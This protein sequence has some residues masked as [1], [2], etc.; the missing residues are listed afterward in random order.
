M[1]RLCAEERV[2]RRSV[3]SLATLEQN[4]PSTDSKPILDSVV[5]FQN[6]KKLAA[7]LS[8]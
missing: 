1:R 7:D 5:I 2:K 4:L 8:K 3:L 6:V